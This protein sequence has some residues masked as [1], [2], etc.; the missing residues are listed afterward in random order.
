M[1]LTFISDT[2]GQEF[3]LPGGDV[4]I[5]CG[6]LSINGYR[7]EII[8]ALNYLHEQLDLYSQILVIP[9]NHD[10]WAERHPQAFQDA[11]I[12][13]GLTPLI[14][15]TITING[16]NFYG[17]P[18]T[19]RYH[20]WAFNYSPEDLAKIWQAIPADTH[21]LIT[22]GPPFKILDATQKEG[23]PHQGCLV[24]KDQILRV[25]PLIHAFGH[26]HEQGGQQIKIGPTW[27]INAAEHVI[28]IKI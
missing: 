2:H 10:F 15:Q 13:G 24:L 17:S 12:M 26:I 19:P 5:H 18:A 28:N 9:G 11:A 23:S 21:V 27:F 3:P 8:K 16:I 25:N 14:N 4:L 6:D 1:Q 22:H 20:D 7:S